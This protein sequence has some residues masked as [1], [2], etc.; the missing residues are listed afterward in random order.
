[1]DVHAR[2]RTEGKFQWL[3]I[4]ALNHLTFIFSEIAKS[5]A[6]TYQAAFQRA[7][8]YF[9]EKQPERHFSR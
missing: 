4:H 6:Q 1:M 3:E 2:Y 9:P 5:S 8:H 7:F